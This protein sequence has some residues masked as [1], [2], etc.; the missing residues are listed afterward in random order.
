MLLYIE[1]NNLLV[2]VVSQSLVKAYT[3]PYA[4]PKVTVDSF[5]CG[6]TPQVVVSGERTYGWLQHYGTI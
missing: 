5:I 4:L 2:V 3:D 6:G 1:L